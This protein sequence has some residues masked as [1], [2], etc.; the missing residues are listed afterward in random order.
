MVDS[1]NTLPY[2]NI[3][4]VCKLK[5]L[6]YTTTYEANFEDKSV[7]LHVVKTQLRSDIEKIR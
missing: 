5:D 2:G 4:I 7:V 3:T 6:Q 1:L